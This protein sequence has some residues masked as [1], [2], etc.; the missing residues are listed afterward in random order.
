MVKLFNWLKTIIAPHKHTYSVIFSANHKINHTFSE[1]D[2][3]IKNSAFDRILY[4]TIPKTYI[5][6][7]MFQILYCKCGTYRLRVIS[8]IGEIPMNLD[9]IKVMIEIDLK[10]QKKMDSIIEYIN[11]HKK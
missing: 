3:N 11:N 9:Y 10:R 1:S 7:G 6:T 2:G 5:G 4:K 8:N